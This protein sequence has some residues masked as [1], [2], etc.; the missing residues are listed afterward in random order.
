MFHHSLAAL[1]RRQESGRMSRLIGFL[2]KVPKVC[3][4]LDRFEVYNYSYGTF[5]S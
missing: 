4:K 5:F 2:A 1:A 3:Y